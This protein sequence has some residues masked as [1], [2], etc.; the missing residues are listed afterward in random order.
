MKK[1][2]C[3]LITS[4]LLHGAVGAEPRSDCKIGRIVDFPVTMVGFQPQAV[5]K[6]N[7]KDATFVADSG[8]FY[9]MISPGRAAEL[10]LHL[11]PAPDGF[12]V[13]GVGGDVRPNIAT[14]TLTIAGVEI[15][16]VEFLVGG[17]DAGAVGLL[18]QNVL[19]LED[20][21]FDLGRGMIRIMRHVGCGKT[22]LAYWVPAGGSYSVL[23]T[24]SMPGER[25]HIVAPIYVNGKRLEAVFDT[26]AATS[27]ISLA[28]AARIGLK[29]GGPGVVA[30]GMSSGVGRSMV[31]T[32]I[33]PVAEVKIGDETIKNSRLRFGGEFGDTDMLIGADF[34]LS[35]R[36]YWS[37][38]LGKMFF[39]YNIGSHIFD[40][41]LL[42]Q[43]KPLTAAGS[44]NGPARPQEPPL[45]DA[46]G[47]S[48]RASVRLTRA[49]LAG[50]LD[51]LDQAVRLAPAHVG[52]LRQRAMVEAR[53]GQPAKAIEDLD[54]LLKIDPRDVEGLVARA[55]IRYA[56]DPKT[57]VRADID[58]ASAAAAKP[59]DTR[60]D[61][62][63][64]Y[65]QIGDYRAAVGQLDLW[66]AAHRDDSRR[67][68]ALNQRCWARA[69]T[70]TQLDLALSDCN[71]ALA[72]MP[73]NPA[74][75][76][77]RGLVR[78]RLGQYAQAIADYDEALAANGKIA[79]S[80]YGR[81]IAKLRLGQKDAGEAD[82][83]KAREL[84]P[85]LPDRAKKLGV[86]P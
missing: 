74:F 16:H 25:T 45:A 62:A 11:S 78:L 59:S 55:G 77:S 19:A 30:A 75:L 57:D 22:D 85:D 12:W 53:M 63:G 70:G 18:G 40:L 38:K 73:H 7:G 3:L 36:I 42:G 34:F 33:G 9:S 69:L 21:E 39:S 47:Y 41:S 83:A 20:T 2:I 32:W 17:S 86:A 52:Y 35:H 64:L 24:K 6:V 84:E 23:E 44:A 54:R 76:D 26:G 8:A 46:D 82:L 15:P 67:P 65:D 28:A 51:D 72:G 80:L 56:R 1:R 66:I 60:L 50:A 5:L 81:G 31:P 48:R 10:G 27:F 79:W 29:P 49:D 43:Q 68:I 13:V 37:D 61:I 4:A 71:A 58:T 14:V